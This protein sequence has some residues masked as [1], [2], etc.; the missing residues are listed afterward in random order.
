MQRSYACYI[1]G[2]TLFTSLVLPHLNGS[3]SRRAMNHILLIS[4]SDP[5]PFITG[6]SEARRQP[7]MALW[8]SILVH[9][10]DLYLSASLE[11]LDVYAIISAFTKAVEEGHDAVSLQLVRSMAALEKLDRCA[12]IMGIHIVTIC[13]SL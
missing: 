12:I 6:L 4:Q 8:R 13:R 5:P 1:V 3:I 9:E 2:I 7:A 10:R 11:G